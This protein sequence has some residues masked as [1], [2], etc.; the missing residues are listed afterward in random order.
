MPQRFTSLDN[1]RVAELLMQGAI[2][3]I[4]TDTVYGL[5]G[6]ATN[7]TAISRMYAAKDRPE[8]AGTIIGA[9]TQQFCE[10][11]F[12]RQ[13]LEAVSR[14]WPASLSVV[15][16]ASGVAGYLKESRSSLPVRIPDAARLGALLKEVGPL[17]TTSANTPGA[18]TST[19]IKM[20]E[21]YFGADVDFY[22]DAGDLGE[23]PPSTII[24][25][26]EKGETI[27]YRHGAVDIASIASTQEH[28]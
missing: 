9:S 14:F 13:Q 12:D 27:V 5:V 26:D 20:A 23:R 16:D 19:T 11:G 18:P 10:L 3:V 8:H 21:R 17:M 15:L 6:S 25:F 4:P 1:P 2:G 24:G 28:R 7:Q 22:V